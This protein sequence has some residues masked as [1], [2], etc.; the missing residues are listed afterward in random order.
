MKQ[1]A[2]KKGGGREGGAEIHANQKHCYCFTFKVP[3][4]LKPILSGLRSR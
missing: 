3:L 2:E 1:L 4:A